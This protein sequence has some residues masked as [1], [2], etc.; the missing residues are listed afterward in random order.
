[1][2]NSSDSGGLPE[3]GKNHCGQ[4]I[5]KLDMKKSLQHLVFGSL[6]A[7]ILVAGSAANA[8]TT[9]TETPKP[10]REWYPV[11]GI[12]AGVDTSTKT[13]SLK[14][15]EGERVLHTDAQSKIEMDGKPITLG[16]IKNGYY[17]SGTLHKEGAEE[18]ILKVKIALEAPAKKGTNTVTKAVAPV[19]A[20]AGE[21]SSTNAVVKKI[22]RKKKTSPDTNAPAS[23]Q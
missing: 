20:P 22:K 12:V 9:T 3:A 8:Q 21:E 1:L 14:K 23:N 7:A 2:D 15:K 19:M 13:I 4:K 17:L 5:I 10:K 16:A 6:F 18:F 11:G